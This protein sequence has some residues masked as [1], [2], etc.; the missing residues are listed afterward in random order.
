MQNNNYTTTKTKIIITIHKPVYGRFCYIRDKWLRH[1]IDDKK[2][3]Y[4][5]FSELNE[6]YKCNAKK[7]KNTG[8]RHEQVFKIPDCPMVLYGNHANQIGDLI[9]EK[10][11]PVNIIGGLMN[12]KPT[13]KQLEK[14]RKAIYGHNKHNK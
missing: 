8:Q 11:E 2:D 5:V 7:W 6:T 1:A 4:V 14:M 13:D 3:L 10:E 9:Q 12:A